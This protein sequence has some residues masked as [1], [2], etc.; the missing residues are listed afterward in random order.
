MPGRAAGQQR[1]G[2][3]GDRVPHEH[4]RGRRFAAVRRGA[5]R[6]LRSRASCSR[7]GYRW[8]RGSPR[9]HGGHDR[10]YRLSQ[11]GPPE[12]V[13]DPSRPT[14]LGRARGRARRRPTADGAT[15]SP[16]CRARWPRFLDAWATLGELGAATTSRRTRASASATTVASTA[17]PVRLARQRLRALAARDEPRL[18]ARARRAARSAERSARPTKRRAAPSSSYQLDLRTRTAG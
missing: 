8:P 16:T 2:L 10:M 4:E 13:L 15:P 12:T 14:A 9:S 1:T 6:A 5:C 18:P 11:S 7:H 17:A 3:R